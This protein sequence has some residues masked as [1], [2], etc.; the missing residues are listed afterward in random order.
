M[1]NNLIEYGPDPGHTGQILY[2]EIAY[3][4]VNPPTQWNTATPGLEAYNAAHWTSYTI[5]LTEGTGKTGYFYAATPAALPAG[6]YLVSIRAAAGGAGPLG[7]ALPADQGPGGGAAP[8]FEA[9]WDGTAWHFGPAAVDLPLPPPGTTAITDLAGGSA[10]NPN[11]MTVVNGQS[12][13][14]PGAFV[15]AYLTSAY[16]ANP[17]TA[18]ILGQAISDANGHWTLNLATGQGACT[19]VA[20]YP[21]TQ[22]ALGSVTV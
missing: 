9:Y 2:A 14:I 12:Q 22:V 3:P 6:L 17:A 11:V 4:A 16:N 20:Y 10:R 18:T 13:P 15:Q 1:P 7:A 19:I 5:Q 8:T 21:G